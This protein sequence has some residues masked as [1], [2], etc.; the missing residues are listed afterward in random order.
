M[1]LKSGSHHFQ[2]SLPL[3][4]Y[5]LLLLCIGSY[6]SG[7]QLYDIIDLIMKNT[8]SKLAIGA[9]FGAGLAG[10]MLFITNGDN[11]DAQFK[12]YLFGGGFGLLMLIHVIF[13]DRSKDKVQIA[14]NF[15]PMF[16]TVL[17][18]GFFFSL[19][20]GKLGV[21]FAC[22]GFFT[23]TYLLYLLIE[24]YLQKERLRENDLLD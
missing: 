3:R 19:I 18:V 16:L 4:S 11:P 15:L 6:L 13:R 7:L 23:L 9:A 21:M 17:G 2:L 22:M 5:W 8:I 24:G 12:M 20:F 14:K 1:R 10:L